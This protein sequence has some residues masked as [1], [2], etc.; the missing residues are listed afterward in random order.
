V[1]RICESGWIT[2]K[3]VTLT[4]GPARKARERRSERHAAQS[5]RSR[6]DACAPVHARETAA[7]RG[8][9]VIVTPPWILFPRASAWIAV[10]G[11]SA[12]GIQPRES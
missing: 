4:R 5:E 12:G 9:F 3:I 1:H 10:C 11:V 6:F 2:L 7:N 8:Q